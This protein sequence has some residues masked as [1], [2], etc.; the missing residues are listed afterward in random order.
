MKVGHARMPGLH[1]FL[2]ATTGTMPPNLMP[3]KL[4]QM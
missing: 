4:I 3:P 1:G 2:V